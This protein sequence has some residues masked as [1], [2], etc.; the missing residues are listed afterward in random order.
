VST[1]FVYDLRISSR[2]LLVASVSDG[3]VA[4][5]NLTTNL[6]INTLTPVGTAFPALYL[7]LMSR[8][9]RIL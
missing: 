6:L 1:T 8:I 2:N 3:T 4:F 9:F 7:D 5:F